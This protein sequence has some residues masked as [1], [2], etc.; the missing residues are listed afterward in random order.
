MN[1]Q[2]INEDYGTY[3]WKVAK[4]YSIGIWSPEDMF[5]HII[6]LLCEMPEDEYDAITS[7]INVMHSFCISRA[8]NV[9]RKELVRNRGRNT[10][11][12]DGHSENEYNLPAYPSEYEV[13]L[14]I[15][16]LEEVLTLKLPDD[17]KKFIL[18]LA[19]PSPTT[20]EIA[21]NNQKEAID[22]PNLRM[23]VKNLVVL[24]RH[25]CEFMELK[26]EKPPSKATISRWRKKMQELLLDDTVV[27]IRI[28]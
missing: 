19:F 21:I 8:I 13:E 2:R 18:E 23:N 14:Q 10:N 12:I 11:D 5:Q 16:E 17:M 6:T 28:G 22:D 1:I 3:I 4:R 24:P 25:V 7:N 27:C 9:V 15:K 26:G 20:V